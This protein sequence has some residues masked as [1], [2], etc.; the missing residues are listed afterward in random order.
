MI[1]A[2]N[3]VRIFDFVPRIWSRPHDRDCLYIVLSSKK[4]FSFSQ[5]LTHKGSA[6]SLSLSHTHTHIL[7]YRDST[8]SF[9]HTF[10]L[11]ETVYTHT[12]T[13]SLS[14]STFWLTEIALSLSLSY[15]LAF[16]DSTLSLF[17]STSW[18]SLTL[19]VRKTQLNSRNMGAYTFCNLFLSYSAFSVGLV[20]GSTSHEILSQHTFYSLQDTFNI[21]SFSEYRR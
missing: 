12:H 2:H 6:L 14:L 7:T 19:P 11:T 18:N 21:Q 20:P 1:C 4:S 17:I 10:W 16:R 9:S 3:Y 8:H 15:I 13:L 5:I